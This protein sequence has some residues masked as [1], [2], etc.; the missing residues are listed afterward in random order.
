[1]VNFLLFYFKVKS[2]IAIAI[3]EQMTITISLQ[4]RE[5]KQDK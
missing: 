5:K 3:I 4:K 1:M 2:L